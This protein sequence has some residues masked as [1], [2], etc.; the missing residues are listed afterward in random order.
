MNKFKMLC[1]FA[2]IAMAMASLYFAKNSNQEY[3]NKLT[4][5]NIEALNASGEVWCDLEDETVCRIVISGVGYGDSKG[6]VRG[7][8]Y[9]K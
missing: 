3:Q 6:T 7:I 2:V 9:L 8:Y 5:S 4:L 1:C